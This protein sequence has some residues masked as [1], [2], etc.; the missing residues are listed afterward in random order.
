MAFDDL[1]EKGHPGNNPLSTLEDLLFHVC[2]RRQSCS[3][4]LAGDVACSWCAISATCV[5]NPAR[6]PILAPLGSAQICPLGPKERWELRALPFGCNASTLTVLSIAVAILGTLAA[7]A[8]GSGVVY[9]AQG[10][11]CRWKEAEYERLDDRGQGSAWGGL[12][13]CRWLVS[14]AHQIRPNQAQKQ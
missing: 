5:P 10:V 2:W 6:L 12:F 8:V 14:L 1:R 4:C 13:H 3:Q 7:I 11:R 9:I